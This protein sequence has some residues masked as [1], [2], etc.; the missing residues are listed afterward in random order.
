MW[1]AI[2]RELPCIKILRYHANS[3]AL[4]TCKVS[5]GRINQ[6]TSD[7]GAGNLA[8]NTNS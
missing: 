6:K 5:E 8:G 1:D 7:T 2:H 3:R 4:N